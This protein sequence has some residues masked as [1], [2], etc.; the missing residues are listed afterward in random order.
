MSVSIVSIRWYVWVLTNYLDS[1]PKIHP[2]NPLKNV[3]RHR[4]TTLSQYRCR[5]KVTKNLE[6]VK[7]LFQIGYEHGH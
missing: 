4:K 5:R 3:A 6:L 2:Y 7:V 1:F